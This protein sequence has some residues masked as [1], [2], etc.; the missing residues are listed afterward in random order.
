[1]R[2]FVSD[3]YGHK[4]LFVNATGRSKKCVCYNNKVNSYMAMESTRFY[5]VGRYFKCEHNMMAL[6]RRGLSWANWLSYLTAKAVGMQV[7]IPPVV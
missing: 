3:Y 6:N 4:L 1:M 5:G 7:Q 2:A